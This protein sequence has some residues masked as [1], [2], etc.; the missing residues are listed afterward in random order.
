VSYLNVDQVQSWLQSTK[1]PLSHV[2]T[3][4]EGLASTTVLGKLSQ[5]YDTSGWNDAATTPVLVIQIM[6]MLVASYELRKFASEEDGRT[7]HA[8]WLEERAMMLCSD[9]VDGCIDIEGLDPNPASALGGGP[10]FWPTDQSTILADTHP[11]DALASPRA[12]SMG[13]YF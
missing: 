4:F 9:I 2:D 1:Y 12:F 11:T 6:S 3:T 13:M 10:L 7:T 8:D 5:R